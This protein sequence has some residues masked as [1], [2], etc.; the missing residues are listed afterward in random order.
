MENETRQR[1]Y[2]GRSVVARVIGVALA[3]GT[4]GGGPLAQPTLHDFAADVEAVLEARGAGAQDTIHVIGHAFG[5]RVAPPADSGLPLQAEYPD[6][7][8][9]VRVPHAGHALLPEQGAIIGEAVV[10]FLRRH[11][12]PR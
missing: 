8:T 6:R 10:T 11:G 9:L 4:G 7:V 5:N 2:R 1:P 12:A 3:A